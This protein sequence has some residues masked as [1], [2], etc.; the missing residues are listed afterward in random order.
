MTGAGYV[1]GVFGFLAGS[2]AGL[3]NETMAIIFALISFVALLV[4]AMDEDK[5]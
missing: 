5:K 3:G 4:A 2:Q 1:W